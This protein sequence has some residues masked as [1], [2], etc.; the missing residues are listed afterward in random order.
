MCGVIMQEDPP[1]TSRGQ[2]LFLEVKTEQECT[3]REYLSI[4]ERY[5]D[6]TSIKWK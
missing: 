4:T 3:S 6:R 2:K 5:I 1:M